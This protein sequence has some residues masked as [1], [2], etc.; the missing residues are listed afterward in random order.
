MNLLHM[1]YAVAVADAGSINRASA[2]LLIAQPNLSRAI[3][4]LEAELGTPI[5]ERSTR[6]MRLTPAGEAYIACA[7]KVLMQMAEMEGLFKSGLGALRRFSLCAPPAGY[8][9][10]ALAD[11]SC[12]LG[13]EAAELCC[14]EADAFATL[15]ALQYEGFHLGILRHEE[16]AGGYFEQLLERS[17]FLWE[18]VSHFSPVLLFSRQSPLAGLERVQ[19][20]DLSPLIAL[21]GPPPSQPEALPAEGLPCQKSI[22]LPGQ[23]SSLQLLC[24]NPRCFLLA[25]PVPAPQL[26][27]FGLMQRPC[28]GLGGPCRDLLAYR[29]GY[30]LSRLDKNFI[31][32]LKRAARKH[33][34][35]GGN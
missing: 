9:E 7:K 12:G 30:R 25:P 17:G 35:P 6:G 34:P 1:K 23:G 13:E 4:E 14:R 10:E 31:A 24:R 18:P 5:F 3:K 28:E 8:I 16:Q 21:L 22:R 32:C 20:S 15:G 33:L 26:A 27:R 11:F 2:R 19:K 29:K